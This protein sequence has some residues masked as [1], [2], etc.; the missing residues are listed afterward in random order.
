MSN[1]R[2]MFSPIHSLTTIKTTKSHHAAYV[3]ILK[4][5]LKYF[6]TRASAR[7][8][9]PEEVYDFLLFAWPIARSG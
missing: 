5:S 8:V 7:Y 4:T 1:K 3:P 9:G 6:G 2:F